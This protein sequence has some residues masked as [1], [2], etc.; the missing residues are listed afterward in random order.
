MERRSLLHCFRLR[1][2]RLSSGGFSWRLHV[3][4]FCAQQQRLALMLLSHIV[5]TG[6]YIVRSH[7]AEIGCATVLCDHLEKIKAYPPDDR[8]EHE[9]AKEEPRLAAT[10]ER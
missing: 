6:D 7:V 5:Q 4:S 10:S 2:P 8:V 3:I 9:V 1:A